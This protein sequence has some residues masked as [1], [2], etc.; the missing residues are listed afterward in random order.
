MAPA[1]QTLAHSPHLPFWNFVQCWR[2]MVGLE[3]TA[4][5]KGMPMAV[6]V[7]RPSS[8]S[9]GIFF[10]GHFCQQAPQP[11]HLLQSTLRAFRRR[12]TLKLPT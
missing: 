6:R 4:W 5:G 7:P 11:V 9:E 3:G 12:W 10:W 8:N 1:W 2:S